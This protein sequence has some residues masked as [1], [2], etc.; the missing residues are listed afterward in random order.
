ML[1][2]LLAAG[3]VYLLLGDRLEAAALLVFATLSVAITVVQSRR[4]ERVLEALRDITSPRA[5]VVRDGQTQRIA[6]R[7]V[8]R[9]DLLVLAEGDRIPAD[10]ILLQGDELLADESLL[11]GESVPV[12][13]QPRASRSADMCRPA[14]PPLR[15]SAGDSP[16]AAAPADRLYAG[17]LLVRGEGLARVVATG[18]SSA[19]GRIGRSLGDIETA[20]PRLQAQTRRLVQLLGGAGICISVLM[21]ALYGLLREDWSQ[22]VLAGIALGMSMLPEELPVVLAVFTAM[23]AW[24]IS[25]ASVLT[26]RAAAIETL[27]SATVLCSDKTGTLTQ[28]RMAIVEGWTPN[29]GNAQIDGESAYVEHQDKLRDPRHDALADHIGELLHTGRLASSDTPVD[30]MEKAFHA[31]ATLANGLQPLSTLGPSAGKPMMLRLWV[32]PAGADKGGL[33]RGATRRVSPGGDVAG[34]AD[35]AS[36]PG[37]MVIACKGAPEAVLDLCR[38]DA[39]ARAEA[40]AAASG[41]A[42]RGLRV[43][44]V[45]R[46]DFPAA[47]GDPLAGEALTEP[48][49]LELV[50]IVGL[51]DPLRPDVPA[52]IAECRSAGI[53]VLMITG[54][55]ADTALAVARAAGLEVAVLAAS[56]TAASQALGPAPL[57]HGASAAD[58]RAEPAVLAGGDIDRLDDAALLDRLARVSV[59]ARIRPEQKLRIVRLLQEAGEVVAMTGD[60]VNDAPA[61]KAADIGIAMGERGTDVGREA[62]ALVL[63]HDD[64][65][66][67]VAAIRL[68]RRIG[69]NLRKAVRF[70]F[71]VHVPVAG[72]ALL[73]LLLDLPLLL[74]PLHIALLEMAIDPLCALVF[75]AETEERTVM[76]RPP[77]QRDEPLLSMAELGHAML[78]GLAAL[79]LCG[80]LYVIALQRGLPADEVRALV[81]VTLVISIFALVLVNRRFGGGL[82]SLRGSRNGILLAVAA[83]IAV[84]LAVLLNWPAAA[85][86]FGFGALHVRDLLA[87]FAAGIG[88]MVALQWQKR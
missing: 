30:P 43:L 38:F 71:A 18:A 45:A 73:P 35:A 65:G 12:G 88:L 85:R 26:R 17:T 5:R 11:T 37:E 31:G 80:G 51:A 33:T 3:G 22:A 29:G 69:D 25:Q 81:F 20:T 1:A 70:I 15:G 67:M 79:A 21:V 57:E 52:A 16:A 2:L 27:G 9:G 58:Q 84:T 87:A 41:M 19:I 82:S 77:R 32:Y 62:A 86:V 54:D 28:N 7:D 42:S 23:G 60:G 10:A 56:E 59:C 68:G 61:L 13:K 78:Q 49:P 63:L 6:G 50:G 72:L 46:A 8:V 76:S 83:P 39:T 24:R 74:G 44:A 48:P 34:S 64:F 14:S 40:L 66:A 47:A 4:S 75:E 55:H 36:G 53:R